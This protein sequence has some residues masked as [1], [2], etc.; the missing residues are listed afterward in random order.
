MQL[1]E[2]LRSN[3]DDAN[4]TLIFKPKTTQ[5]FKYA[6]ALGDTESTTAIVDMS[7]VLR[8]K[9]IVLDDLLEMADVL[10]KQG[11]REL[12]IMAEKQKKENRN[13]S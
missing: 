2:Y 5:S 4:H 7:D 12:D 8:G 9:I 10:E 11:Q 3:R 6:G 1:M 13:G